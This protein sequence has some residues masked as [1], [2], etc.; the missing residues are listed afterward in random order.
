MP[1]HGNVYRSCYDISESLPRILF[2][3]G[4][5]TKSALII[6]AAHGSSYRLFLNTFLNAPVMQGTPPARKQ[7]PWRTWPFWLL[8]LQRNVLAIG[9]ILAAAIS[10]AYP[11]PG[12]AIASWQVRIFVL[13]PSIAAD[14]NNEC[15][16]LRNTFGT[17]LGV[18][19]SLDQGKHS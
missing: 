17:M 18:L 7:A 13:S 5:W 2:N 4:A 8:K 3:L 16:D 1:R 6:N 14:S 11:V 9:F 15:L 10:L 19:L 12:R